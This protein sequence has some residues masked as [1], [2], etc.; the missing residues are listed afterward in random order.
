[1]MLVHPHLL[2]G[3]RPVEDNIDEDYTLD[4]DNAHTVNQLRNHIVSFLFAENT[5]GIGQDAQLC[6]KK[7]RSVPWCS[8]SVPWSDMDD[9]V[10]LLSHLFSEAGRTCTVDVFHAETDVMVGE[11]GRLWFDS[12]WTGEESQETEARG[13]EYRSRVVEGADHDFILDP[14]FGASEAW[15]RR[16]G[17]AFAG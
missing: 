13:F 7:P 6:L 8:P 11:K 17:E 2:R 10:P 16:V 15:L 12:C 9:A 1:M 3:D 14:V 4:L 5:D